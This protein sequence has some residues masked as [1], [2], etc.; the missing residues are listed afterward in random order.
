MK[1]NIYMGDN[2]SVLKHIPSEYVDLIYIDPPFNTGHTQ[3]KTRLKTSRNPDGDRVGFQGYRYKTEVGETTSFEDSFDDY[4]EFLAPR[5]QE[6][7]RVLKPTGTLYFHIDYREVHYCKILLDS[8]F[9][10]DSFLNE[11]IWAYD[12]G[13]K[14]KSRWSA[15]HDN[16]LVYVK[17]RKNYTFN[18][19]AIDRIPYMAPK[20]AGPEKAARG[21]LP[22]DVWWHT[23]VPPGGKESTGYATQKPEAIITRIIKTSSNEG[24]LVLDFFAGSG[25]TGKVAYELDR[26]FILIDN[27]PQAID[28]MKKRLDK[29]YFSFVNYDDLESVKN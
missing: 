28:V 14:S 17:D 25:T 13:A 29:K 10:R 9:G 12:Y 7:Y 6:A 23:I 15:K 3:S 1:A 4:L 27:N 19:D 16:I 8:I 26:Q 22:T 5:L 2:L 21:K 18:T 24:D 20:L 11:L